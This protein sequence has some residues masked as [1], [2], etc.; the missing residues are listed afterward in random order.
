MFVEFGLAAIGAGIRCDRVVSFLPRDEL[1]AW[2]RDSRTHA[3]RVA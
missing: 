2:S 1:L 3:P